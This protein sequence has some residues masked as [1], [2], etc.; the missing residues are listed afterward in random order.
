MPGFQSNEQSAES[1]K[2]VVFAVGYGAQKGRF[3]VY[4]MA[5]LSTLFL[6]VFI[7]GGGAIALV[8]AVMTGAAAY[9]FYPLI[10]TGK[11]RLG[12]NQYGIFIDGFGVIAWR[13]VD[14]V[15]VRTFAVRT[16]ETN[17]LHIKLSQPLARALTSDWRGLPL[18]RL[19]MRLPWAMTPDNVVRINLEPFARTPDE[20][21][22]AI[23]Q[24]RKRYG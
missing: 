19:L 8:L 5:A 21:V 16:I 4:V 18:Y 23:T 15:L 20:I 9:Y 7:G 11:P 14:D 24:I 12:A 22:Q 10:E 1:H 6:A 3:R 17:E 13:A 2:P